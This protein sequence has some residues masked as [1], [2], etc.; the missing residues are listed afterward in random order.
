MELSP[1]RCLIKVCRHKHYLTSTTRASK[2]NFRKSWYVSVI[3]HVC[4]ERFFSLKS[5]INLLLCALSTQHRFLVHLHFWFFFSSSS[6][7]LAH[8]LSE[9]MN[10][11][12]SMF[13]LTTMFSNNS[14]MKLFTQF[15]NIFQKK[16]AFLS[17]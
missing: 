7:L 8:F 10:F 14:L 15:L 13:S 3:L 1:L 16:K 12:S 5:Y 9:F 11:F 17:F 6:C 2:C 4:L